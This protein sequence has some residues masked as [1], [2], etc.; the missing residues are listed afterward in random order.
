MV[1]RK[2]W[3]TRKQQID[4]YNNGYN[5]EVGRYHSSLNDDERLATQQKWES[6]NIEVSITEHVFESAMVSMV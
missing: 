6:G 4:G 1:N 5:C 3:E 2:Y